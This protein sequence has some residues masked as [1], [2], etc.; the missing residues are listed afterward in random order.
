MWNFSGDC[1][2]IFRRLVYWSLMQTKML[3]PG[4]NA[5]QFDTSSNIS[6]TWRSE[7][8]K[9]EKIW[10][11][12]NHGISRTVFRFYSDQNL[13]GCKKKKKNHIYS[14]DQTRCGVRHNNMAVHMCRFG[15]VPRIGKRRA[16]MR[17]ILARYYNRNPYIKKIIKKK[18]LDLHADGYRTIAR[19]PAANILNNIIEILNE[20][21][22]KRTLKKIIIMFTLYNKRG[23]WKNDGFGARS[24]P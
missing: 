8:K 12:F 21:Q 19:A 10:A 9:I 17:K 3:W 20:I 1:W 4:R 23:V 11:Q 13:F 6:C 18:I 15:S 14:P 24:V 16:K 22:T 7:K 2:I 5:Q